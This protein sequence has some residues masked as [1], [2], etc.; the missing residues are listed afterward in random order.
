MSVRDF[1]TRRGF[2]HRISDGIHG[3]ALAYVLG[4]DVY[5][6]SGLLAADA[7]KPELGGNPR[8]Y[9]LKSR[10]PHFEPKAKAVIQLFMNG[11]PSQMDLLDPKPMHEKH[12]GYLKIRRLNSSH[13]V[14]TNVIF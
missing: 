12:D 4:G 7:S 5:G 13:T 9:D 3:A 8:S 2:F 1:T 10:K 14:I 11:G 6:G